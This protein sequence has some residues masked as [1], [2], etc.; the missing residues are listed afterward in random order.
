MQVLPIDV[1]NQFLGEKYLLLTHHLLV[2]SSIVMRNEKFLAVDTTQLL[3]VERLKLIFSLL[4]NPEKI[5]TS[6]DFLL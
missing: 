2:G 6:V 1:L 4:S 3:G 5:A